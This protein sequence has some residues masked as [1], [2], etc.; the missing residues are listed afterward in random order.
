MGGRIK[1]EFFVM[2]FN[3]KSN[4]RRANNNITLLK[5]THTTPLYMNKEFQRVREKRKCLFNIDL[6]TSIR[7]RIRIRMQ[8]IS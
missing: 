1:P 8:K 5:N 6:K 2:T 4:K 7:I 3:S